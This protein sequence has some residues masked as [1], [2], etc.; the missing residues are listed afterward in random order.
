MAQRSPST[1]QWQPALLLRAST[2]PQP[3]PVPDL[4]PYTD[5]IA[6]RGREWLAGVWH[7]PLPAAVA[8]ASPVLC[9]SVTAILDGSVADE[10]RIRR[11]VRSVAAYLMRW[12]HR[13]TPFGV[14]AG[15]A[16][17]R[18]AQDPGVDWGTGFHTQLRPDADWLA[19]VIV[20][21][22]ADPTLLT[23]LKVTV[24][25]T[26]I[27]RGDRHVV[28]GK[29]TTGRDG[30]YAPVEVSVRRTRPVAAVLELARTPVGYGAL[31]AMLTARFPT[32]RT[33]R[34][35]QF[36]ADLVTR[37]VLITSLWP[38]MNEADP[39]SHLCAQL[40]Q[41]DV[42]SLP[43]LAPVAARLTEIRGMLETPAA[44]SWAADSRLVR[45]MHSVSR[46]APGPVLV[47]AALDCSVQVPEPL[48][49]EAARAAD[50]MTQLS[51][52]PQGY[53]HWRDYHQRF[54]DRYGT[55]MPVPV[56]ELTADSGL[57]YPAGYL[58]ADRDRAPYQWT[59]RDETI[60]R[61]LQETAL[62]GRTELVLTPADVTELTAGHTAPVHTAPR[63]EIAV[64]V[65]APTLDAVRHGDY[66]L[67][68]TGAPR[69]ASSM[70][71]RFARLLPKDAQTALGASY[72]ATSPDTVPAQLSFSPRRRRNENVARVP[73]LLHHSIPVAEHTT[74]SPGAIALEDLAVIADRDRF[75]LV[76]AST[77]QYIEP[78]VPHALEASVHTPPLARFLAEIT[79]AHTAVYKS[80]S[81]GAASP[82]PFLPRVRYRRT[83]LRPARWL[84]SADDL[85]SRSA[86]MTDWDKALDQHRDRLRLPDRFA[87]VENDQQLP[88]DVSRH[89]DRA[90][91]RSCLNRVR[92]VE[93][94]EAPT[95][96]DRAWIG[97]PHELL[98]PLAHR[99]AD[100]LRSARTPVALTM[101]RPARDAVLQARLHAH[102]ARFSQI[103]TTHLPN[104]I[105]QFP[106]SP[107]WWF[108]RHRDPHHA[109]T[110][111]Y[112]VLSLE[113]S[114]PDG[115]GQAAAAV[116]AWA[117][118]LDR[119]HLARGLDLVPVHPHTGLYG[120]G[121]AL[122]AAH[123]VFAAD[124]AAALAQIR[125]A[126]EDSSTAQVLAGTSMLDLAAGLIGCRT[127]AADWLA[128]ALPRDTGPLDHA[129]S[130][131]AIALT[132]PTALDGLPA[133]SMIA[134]AW[135]ARGAALA[136][137]RQYLA[138]GPDRS[139]V[140]Q[141][142][143]DL[144][145]VRAL[146]ADPEQQR[147]ATRLARS[148]ALH[149]R[150]RRS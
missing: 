4:D 140:L 139:A 41:A 89:L 121:A 76:R 18:P 82:L 110:G 73:Q 116:R 28:A 109:G 74:A 100:T 67:L 145:Q 64:E 138:A 7:G 146:A 128:S 77:G 65:H 44:E 37:H 131:R 21:L 142:L 137:Y 53:P 134:T 78:R 32:A 71:G 49:A 94:R 8:V 93:L 144:H 119:Q 47:D 46:S 9:Q 62:A 87:L 136:A 3:I 58:G 38:P 107:R 90:L 6:V 42:H 19:D 16:P 86:P 69:P 148:C 118:D 133:E 135:Q 149:V 29:P 101:P 132:A 25:N 63:A 111:Q 39:L 85:P 108:H 20:R 43:G 36:L 13:P 104:L 112:L 55:G 98:V 83:I 126:S 103:L 54:L 129:L 96:Q 143:L 123:A 97:R 11:A 56:L 30:G 23:R 5:D 27:R 22:E 125:A 34:L 92:L 57:G 17:A 147:V 130:R 10:R 79:T 45:A 1:Y 66:R 50:L 120:H 60:L 31:L 81:F 61:L 72:T 68:V 70:L 91:L 88:I 12:N 122:D 48:L 150:G 102:P 115:Y 105:G 24:N 75:H 14:F 80:F 15:I 40:D 99:Q 26:G 141:S 114:D 35:D 106:G 84:L 124:S 52:H 113:I 2:A 59:R 33:S 51:P 95:A 127:E 117:T